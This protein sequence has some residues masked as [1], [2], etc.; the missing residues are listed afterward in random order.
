MTHFKGLL[1]SME[2]SAYYSRDEVVLDSNILIYGP[3]SFI[4]LPLLFQI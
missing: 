2:H 1:T 3:L 4:Q